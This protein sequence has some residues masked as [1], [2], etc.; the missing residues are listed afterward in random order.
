MKKLYRIDIVLK[1]EDL[2]YAQA[3]IF[4]HI[5]YGWEEEILPDG[6]TLIRIHCEL[7]ETIK[8]VSDELIWHYPYLSPQMSVVEHKDWTEAWKQYFTPVEAGRF[9]VLPSWEKEEQSHAYPDKTKL[10]IEP[11]SA[12]GTGHHATTALCL[13][14]ISDL[15][16]KNAILSSYSFLDLGCGTGIL[17]L[18]LH[19]LGLNGLCT[20]IDPVAMANTKE[21]LDLNDVQSGID[22]S[23]GSIEQ[24]K[25]AYDV[26]VA[27]I[28]AQ[29]LKELSQDIMQ[30]VKEKGILILSGILSSQADDVISYYSSLG[31]PTILHAD[32][33]PHLCPETIATNEI[34]PSETWV[35]L[36]FEK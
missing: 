21:N 6:K 28:L 12:F 20:D 1:P 26:V 14:A 15:Y 33:I 32:D 23:T 18:A 8:T 36:I 19:T 16:E 30:S 22:L 2:E 9:V 35:A 13:H 24:A 25:E 11:K 34:K 29:P 10:Y 17:G 7:E 3:L 27:N 31:K 4:Q 5:Q